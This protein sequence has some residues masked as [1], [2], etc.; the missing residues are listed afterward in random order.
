[1]SGIFGS[2]AEITLSRS[3]LRKFAR[4]REL[5]LFVVTTILWGYPDGMRGTNVSDIGNSFPALLKLLEAARASKID[6]WTVHCAELA[7]IRGVGLSTYTKFL[8]FLAIPIDGNVAM[9]LDKRITQVVQRQ[10]FSELAPINKL[11]YDNGLRRYPEYLRW[12]HST[13]RTLNVPTENLEFFL[14]EFGRNLKEATT[15]HGST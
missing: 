1:L 15:P 5:D 11:S 9:I 13:A 7:R 6:A 14:F 8:S 4:E 10:A 3:D 12:I 2:S